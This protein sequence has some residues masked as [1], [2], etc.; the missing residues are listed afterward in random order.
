MG[1]GGAQ[2][3]SVRRLVYGRSK[4]SPGCSRQFAA[5]EECTTTALKGRQGSRAPSV[6]CSGQARGCCTAA[7]LTLGS[8]AGLCALPLQ[9]PHCPLGSL[10]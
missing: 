8:Q 2:I 1:R 9:W 3:G 7:G 5:L 6:S 4:R 10:Q